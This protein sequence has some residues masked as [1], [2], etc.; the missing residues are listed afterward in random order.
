MWISMK[1]VEDKLTNL[2]ELKN[3]DFCN[4]LFILDGC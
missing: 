1:V 3:L 4:F 2:R